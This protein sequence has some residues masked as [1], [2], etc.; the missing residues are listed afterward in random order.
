MQPNRSGRHPTAMRSFPIVL[1]A[2][3]AAALSA[4]AQVLSFRDAG[5]LRY[6][7]GGV[8][9]EERDALQALRR[10]GQLELL[11]ASEKRGAYLSAI[12]VE[13]AGPGGAGARFRSDGPM[14]LVEAPPGAWKVRARVGAAERSRDVKLTSR[15]ARA[16]LTFPDEP[17]DGVRAS[18][19]EKRQARER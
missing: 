7:C 9:A 18:E 8:G 11:F 4:S 13:V 1:A 14:C 10:P 15:G 17:W 6:V 19:E 5:G 16:T 12:D 2:A 3:L